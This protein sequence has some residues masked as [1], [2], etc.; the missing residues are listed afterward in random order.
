MALGMSGSDFRKWARD[1]HFIPA[2][3]IGSGFG[4]SVAA[5]RLARAGIHTLVLERGRRWPI[6]S[7]GDTFATFEKQDG[8]AA[9]LS[10]FSA[11]API[12]QQFGLTPPQLDMFAGVLEPIIAQGISVAAGAGVG[13]GSLV[14]NGIM[15]QPR[16]DLF[17][18]VLPS[19]IDY[20]EMDS[21]FYPRV[22]SV[23]KPSPIPQDLLSTSFYQST[24]VN[25][26]QAAR[27]GLQTRPVDLA[28]DWDL[29]REEIAGIRTPSAIAGE[30]WFGLNSGAKKSLDQNYLAM[31]EQSG[32]VEILPLHVVDTITELRESSLYVVSANQIDEQG[33]IVARRHFACV[34]LFL[35]AGSVGTTRLLVRSRA[36]SALPRLNKEVGR[37]WG[38]NGD[39]VVVRAG[40]PPT[41]PGTGGPGG[42]FIAEDLENPIEPTSLTELVTP[43]HLA[44]LPGMATYVGMGLP[45]AVGEFVYDPQAD[46]AVLRWPPLTDPR[47]ADFLAAS[48]RMLDTLNTSNTDGS[49]QPTTLLNAPT[50]TAHPLGGAAVG[51][52]CDQY[53]RVRRHQ[54][55]YVIDGAFIPGSTGIANPSLTIAALAERS[56]DRILAEDVFKA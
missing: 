10:P 30:S 28:M 41:N 50:L 55:L 35:A 14:Y 40:L 31:A 43:R 5:L 46:Q 37:Q 53:G 32:R 36:I 6:T 8:R 11:I 2:L 26:E 38:N 7:G 51:A 21:V 45:P 15:V 44:Q 19:Q 54:R 25:L 39:F 24:R 16:R 23:I 18:R 12:E 20:D 56:M 29:V 9:W 22:R 27:A 3:I 33:E 13:G 52:V 42:H 4:G 47:L 1:T 17:Q 49:F 48:R 34:H